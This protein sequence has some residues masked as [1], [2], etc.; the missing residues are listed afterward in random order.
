VSTEELKDGSSQ[1]LL[2]FSDLILLR[3]TKQCPVNVFKV[4]LVGLWGDV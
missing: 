2:T 4:V 1:I 3:N